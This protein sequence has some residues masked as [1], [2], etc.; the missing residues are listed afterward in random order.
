[1]HQ[2]ALQREILRVAVIV[3]AGL[4]AGWSIEY[5]LYGLLVGLVISQIFSIKNADT[6]FRW[7]YRSGPAPHDSG[8]VGYAADRIQ[9]RENQLKGRIVQQATQIQRINQGIESLV[10][11]VVILNNEGYIANFNA[12]A[13]KMLRLQK[14]DRGQHIKNFIR[15]PQFV[16]YFD[17]AD[18]TEPL[19]FELRHLSLQI[20]LTESGTDQKI[21]LIRD[22]T[23]RKRVETM[24]QNFIAD[25]S[26]ELRT[27]LTVINGYLEMLSEAELPS[28]VQKAIGHMDSQSRRMTAIVNDLI[29]LS[30][31]ESASSERGGQWFDIAHMCNEVI[32]SLQN[33]QYSKADSGDASDK[34]NHIRLQSTNNAEVEGFPDEMRS[35]L[36]NLITNALKYGQDSEVI[37]ELT[38]SLKGLRVSVKDKGIG[39]PQ[40]HISRITERFYRVDESRESDIGG[41]GLGLAIVKHALEHHDSALIIESTVGVGSTFSFVIPAFRARK[42]H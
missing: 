20:Q 33:F 17:A 21:V 24:R 41:S 10:D 25:V 9:R 16:R 38:F 29:E 7:S 42:I 34:Q 13:I 15:V 37:V 23:E 3:G 22:V 18:F 4:A 1:M 14:G 6:L 12:A 32:D 2:G 19:Q 40:D 27:P 39:I 5:P 28:A 11:G 36:T 30:K 8:L 31:L 26:H 35:V